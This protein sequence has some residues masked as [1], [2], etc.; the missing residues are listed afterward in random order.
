MNIDNELREALRRKPAPADLAD[1]VLER[2]RRSAEPEGAAAEQAPS[3]TI[4]VG[5]PRSGA[6]RWLAAAAVLTLAVGGARYYDARQ[7]AAETERVREELRVALQIT[8]DTLAR[9]QVKISQPSRT[10]EGK[11]KP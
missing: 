6:M 7:Q 9:V 1:R 11:R 3:A 5:A 10:D 2:A 4:R 8:N